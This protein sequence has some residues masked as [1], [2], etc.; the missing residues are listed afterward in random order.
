M[1]IRDRNTAATLMP[2]MVQ[3]KLTEGGILKVATE[4]RRRS[5]IKLT[6]RFTGVDKGS[7]GPEIR[8]YRPADDGE[9][10]HPCGHPWR[11]RMP[12]YGKT[13]DVQSARARLVKLTKHM[14]KLVERQAQEMAKLIFYEIYDKDCYA[15]HGAK[16][17][18]PGTGSSEEPLP[19]SAPARGQSRLWMIDS[20]S[21]IHLL[22]KSDLS[23]VE[24]EN[25]R[26]ATNR[27]KLSTAN[28]ITTVDKSLTFNLSKLHL[29][30]ESYIFD[31][32]PPGAGVLSQGKTV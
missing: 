18:S 28:G 30:G 7:Y 27:M 22:R 31:H 26:P 16:S 15:F 4:T 32:A 6:V 2:C 1:R 25:V 12:K 11:T 29:G 14:K 5:P 23:N 10:G 13:Q 21:S 9:L 19:V 24:K 8:T 20:G 3:Y 17:R